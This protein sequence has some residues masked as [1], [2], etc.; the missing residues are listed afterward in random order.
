LG[1]TP[2]KRGEAKRG[3]TVAVALLAL[4][5]APSAFGAAGA[6]DPTFGGDGRV[7][8]NVGP[9][10]DAAYALAIQ[11]DGKL[12][13]A[14]ERDSRHGRPEF[15]LARY[16]NHGRSD[17]SFG[18]GG[19][20][21]VN[22][23]GF[24]DVPSATAIQS[25]G[26]IVVAGTGGYGSFAVVRFNIDGSLDASFGGDGIV[27]TNLTSGIEI[28]FGLAIQTDGKI[29]VVGLSGGQVGDKWGLVRYN[30]DGTLDSSF[31]GGDGIVRTDIT[32]RA[33]EA[34]AVQIQ[35][36]GKIVVSGIAN[37]F[38]CDSKFALA[39]YATDGTL[40]LGF[41]GGDG[42]VITNFTVGHSGDDGAWALALQPDG[43]IIAAGPA[44]TERSLFGGRFGVA[45]YLSD[46]SLDTSFGGDGKVYTNLTPGRDLATD[47]ELQA[48]G[49]IVVGGTANFFSRNGR[50]G[51]VRYLT[52]G[53]RDLTFGRMGKVTTNF[54]KGSDRAFTLAIQSD[55]G[56][57][58]AGLAG[59]GRRDTK[60]A[61]ARYLGI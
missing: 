3:F 10:Y 18:T 1:R 60:F 51:I 30:G 43:A 47:V 35:P 38:C 21:V 33:D 57:V 56:I 58:A 16:R 6:L 49:K 8:T 24:Y 20:V 15:A 53:R 46:G 50:F 28:A 2:A 52:N 36:D 27:R 9:H 17:G 26:K 44:G 42:K 59:G 22:L 29:V 34:D 11:A 12:V 54:S 25:D 13:V 19:R 61:L 45:R 4:A 5:V 55:G 31:G 40:D 23:P 7:T 14:G 32:H 48:D 37:R 39:R 41:G